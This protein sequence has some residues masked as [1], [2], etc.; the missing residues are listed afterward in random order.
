MS[1]N[2]FN[3]KETV[4][5]AQSVNEIE[6]RFKVIYL[7]N[8]FYIGIYVGGKELNIAAI[9]DKNKKKELD[10]DLD[11][12]A[13]M[14]VFKRETTNAPTVG[15]LYEHEGKGWFDAS[16]PVQ[17]F[18]VDTWYR[19]NV[20]LQGTNLHMKFWQEDSPNNGGTQTYAVTALP[21]QKTIGVISSGAAI[22]YQFIKPTVPVKAI[23]ELRPPTGLCKT[24][25]DKPCTDSSDKTNIIP[26][27]S[28]ISREADAGELLAYK[29]TP[30]V[31]Q[32]NPA[33]VTKDQILKSHFIYTTQATKLLKNGANFNDDYIVMCTKQFRFFNQ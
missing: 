7:L 8:T 18:G 30:P 17:N 23:T 14:A 15:N 4:P 32:F 3:Q 31:G 19:L 1:K 26:L 2:W 21:S 5:L 20:Q 10:L 28:E 33:A 12:L 11:N 24:L 22:E 16:V 27:S 25:P 9:I 29:L 13:K 6:I